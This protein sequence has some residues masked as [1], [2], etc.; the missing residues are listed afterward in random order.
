MSEY[1]IQ[2]INKSGAKQNVAIYQSYPNVVGG[3]PLVW[4]LKNINNTNTNTFSWETPWAL[5]WGTSEQPLTEGV[6]WTSGG[7]AQDIDPN[8]P[9]GNNAMKV[10]YAGNDFKSD[11]A[12]HEGSLKQGSMLVSTDTSFTVSDSLNMSISVYMN[13][14]PTFAMQGRPNGKYRFDTHPVYYICVTDQKEGVAVSGTFVTSPTEAKF[15][16]GTTE[17]KFELNETLQFKQ[18]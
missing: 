6:K 9:T 18:V 17:L 3:L 5:N 14:K 10:S 16:S 2:V 7:T 4:V 15:S 1:S 11:P 13:G 8:S 12:Y